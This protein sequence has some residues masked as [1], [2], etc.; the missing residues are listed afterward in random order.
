[1]N[2]SNNKRKQ[3]TMEK[4]DKAFVTLLQKKEIN[5]INVTD[6]VNLAGINRSTF[7][8]HY[9]DI[10]DLADKIKEK[11]WNDILSLYQEE[12]IGKYHSY[13]FLKLFEHIK[14]NQIYYKTLFKLNFDFSEY[15]DTYKS[16][17]IAL[18]YFTSMKNINYHV[19]FFKAGLNAIIREWIFNGCKESPEEINDILKNEYKGKSLKN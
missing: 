3:T 9:I 2:I 16:D 1:M 19:V 7:Y 15:L 10:Y 11:M 17:N 18:K 6:L 13:N 4:I 8:I 14:N 12:S 5:E